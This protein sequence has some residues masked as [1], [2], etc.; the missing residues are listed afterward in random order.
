MQVLTGRS[1]TLP[2]T[3]RVRSGDTT[4]QTLRV[5]FFFS[6]THPTSRINLRTSN[7]ACILCDVHFTWCTFKVTYIQ[8][9]VPPMWHTHSFWRVF[10]VTCIHHS[11]RN[12]STRDSLTK[13]VSTLDGSV[14]TDAHPRR[15]W[16]SEFPRISRAHASNVTFILCYVHFNVTY[17]LGDEHSMKRKFNVTYFQC[18]VHSSWRTLNVTYIQ[19]DVHQMWCSSNVTCIK[20][21]VHFMRRTFNVTYM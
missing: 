14:P 18:D 9:D 17:N 20:Y 5:C 8:C 10:Y 12:G 4:Q 7:V 19:R 6:T 13:D 21:H 15:R 16:K 2:W 1:N 3:R 11:T